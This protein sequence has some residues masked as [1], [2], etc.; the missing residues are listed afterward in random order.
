MS[1]S[2]KI[3]KNAHLGRLVAFKDATTD[4]IAAIGVTIYNGR[5]VKE[6]MLWLRDNKVKRTSTS[7]PI[8]FPFVN[9]YSELLK[10]TKNFK[11]KLFEFTTEYEDKCVG[12]KATLMGFI[13]TTSENTAKIRSIQGI[14]KVTDPMFPE[15]C[16]KK[17]AAK[18]NDGFSA[19]KWAKKINMDET[20]AVIIGTS[21]AVL[22]CLISSCSAAFD[23]CKKGS[24]SKHA[25]GIE[26]YKN[27]IKLIV[28]NLKIT[29]NM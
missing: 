25:S 12:N 17:T 26:D 29:N 19:N 11:T 21:I 7:D 24:P 10:T 14:Y 23:W 18:R 27:T 8:I 2:E 22:V 6:Y 5:K 28:D 20:D 1:I 16:L 13:T 9:T 3:K 15:R 4:S